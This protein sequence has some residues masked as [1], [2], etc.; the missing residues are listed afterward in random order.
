MNSSV[1]VIVAGGTG[2]RMAGDIPKTY[3]L[4]NGKPVIAYSV[5]AFSEH[6]QIE[7]I[8]VVHHVDHA[9]YL[10]PIL[11]QFS[12][13]ETVLG[14]AT[15]QE[16]V[17]N[18]LE[19][20]GQADNVLIHDA[21]R[22]MVSQELI[23]RMLGSDA[24]AALP[25]V[26][27]A[28]TIKH[29]DGHTLDRSEL[30]A[31]QTP[32][33]FDYATILKL[34][35]ENTEAVTD[36][37][38]LAEAAGINVAFVQGD[39]ANRK[40]TTEED[41]KMMQSA[42]HIAVGNGYDVH[43]FVPHEGDDKTIMIC[44]VAVECEMAIEGH[45]DGDVGLHALTDA[46]LGCIGNGDIGHHFSSDNPK[47]KGAASELFLKEAIRLMKQAGGRLSH[48]DIT[49]IAQMPK[50][51]PHR[52]IMRAQV[53]KICEIDVTSVSVKATTTDH[54]GFIGRKEGLAAQAT[55][56]VIL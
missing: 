45:S 22:P 18:G 33:A 38:M 19:A 42:P 34:H 43:A 49:L 48:C 21:A 4:L 44:G 32:Q 3:R 41:L 20:V 26:P 17:R 51:A 27:V 10:Q 9:D 13:V 40:I 37:V 7:R 23:T 2:S 24:R 14:G 50:L 11:A 47:W 28:D 36:D 29:K 25:V 1:A 12:Q 54:L 53:A 6:P 16:S 46:I 15:R 56:T 8:I 5:Q 31:A 30:F 35:R 39:V 52:E 55:A